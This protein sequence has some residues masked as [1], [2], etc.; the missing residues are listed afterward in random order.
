MMGGHPI[1]D[2]SALIALSRIGQL[3]LLPRLYVRVWIPS[4]VATE[5]GPMLAAQSWL[6]VDTPASLDPRVLG[7]GLGHGETEVISLALER[8]LRAV[9][10]DEERAR[11]LAESLRLATIGTVGVAVQAK[12]Q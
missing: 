9:I 2:S 10:L 4:A 6:V 7:A 1:V 3:D 11:R 8:G 12:A 5:V